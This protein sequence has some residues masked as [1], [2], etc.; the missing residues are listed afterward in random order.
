MPKEQLK[1]LTEQ[2]Y[3]VLLALKRERCGVDI[4]EYVLLRTDG[5]LRLGPGT[6]YSMLSKFEDEQLIEKTRVEGRRQWYQNID[7]IK[8][9]HIIKLFRERMVGSSDCIYSHFLEYFYTPYPFSYGHTASKHPC[10]LVD[11]TPF[12][13][14]VCKLILKPSDEL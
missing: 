14:T 10:I 12:S 8:V 7:A 5:R 1:T 13:L 3:Y 4:T 9:T 2:M 11:T 6:L